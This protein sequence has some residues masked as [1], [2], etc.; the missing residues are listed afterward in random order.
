[1]SED[2]TWNYRAAVAH[3]EAELDRRPREVLSG[4]L[5]ERD[6]EDC[7]KAIVPIAR[8]FAGSFFAANDR[9]RVRDDDR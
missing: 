2:A 8:D 4:Y 5:A 6:V 1:M 9:R 3:N 7:V